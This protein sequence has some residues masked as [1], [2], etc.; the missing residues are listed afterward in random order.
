MDNVCFGSSNMIATTV[1]LG[2]LL[3][4][5]QIMALLITI[6]ACKSCPVLPLMFHTQTQLVHTHMPPYLGKSIRPGHIR[7]QICIATDLVLFRTRPQRC[8]ALAS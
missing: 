1:L 6:L 3:E 4:G 5:N 8:L 2:R 7:A